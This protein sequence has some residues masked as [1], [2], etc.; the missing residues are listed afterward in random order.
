[1]TENSN[2]N[3]ID[4]NSDEDISDLENSKSHMLALF[5]TLGKKETDLKKEKQMLKVELDESQKK[6]ERLLQE[7]EKVQGEKQT[8]QKN[9][10]DVQNEKR[11]E[12]HSE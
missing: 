8:L 7:I 1:M 11:A 4:V 3:I 9:L 2:M 10:E 12:R 6:N 5:A